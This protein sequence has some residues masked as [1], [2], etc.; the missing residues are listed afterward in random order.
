MKNNVEALI[1]DSEFFNKKIAT[2]VDVNK[3]NDDE[4]SDFELITN[5]V[6]SHH[7][8]ALTHFNRLGFTLAEGELIFNKKLTSLPYCDESLTIADV[9]DIDA[10][11]NLAQISYTSTRFRE[12]WFTKEQSSQF[13]GVW[14]E[15]AVLGLFDDICLIIKTEQ[16]LQGFVSL[17]KVGDDMKIGLIAV[18][19]EAQGQ[20]VAK[21]LLTLAEIYAL[22]HQCTQVVVATQTSNLKATNLYIR[23]NYMLQESSYWLYKTHF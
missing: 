5:K 12:P 18:A 14:A 23:N 16:R 6:A 22:D 17:K 1:W 2:V 4:F 9:D 19:P 13:Y 15:K 21:R 20:G 8:L 3:V 10:I 7:Y 11:V